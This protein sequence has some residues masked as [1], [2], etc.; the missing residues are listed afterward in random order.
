MDSEIEVQL[1]EIWQNIDR[2]LEQRPLRK[3]LEGDIT[4][5]LKKIKK[6][7]FLLLSI[8]GASK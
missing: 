3:N 7:F 5:E 4:K 8:M 2:Y 1:E 6:F